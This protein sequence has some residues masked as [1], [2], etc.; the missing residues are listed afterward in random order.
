MADLA[1][2]RGDEVAP[3]EHRDDVDV[4]GIELLIKL[5]DFC[6]NAV[7]C[8][9]D[10]L[11]L[12]PHDD[13]L[14]RRRVLVKAQDSLGLLMRVA[15]FAE[16]ANE[17]R[18]AVSLGHDDIAEIIEGAHEPDAADDQALVAARHP[19]AARIGAV[20]GDRVC[21]V[22]DAY[23]VTQ[24]LSG[25]QIEPEL[26]REASEIIHLCDTRDLPQ[27]RLDDPA[28]I[29]GQV[30]QVLRVRLNRVPVNFQLRRR[31]RV[32]TRRGAWRQ[33]CVPDTLSDPLPF[34]VILGAV[35]KQKIDLG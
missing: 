9:R 28:L 24:E 25:V 23:A 29:F 3:V 18:H 35:A 34:P 22:V 6:V 16:V 15:Q 31:D 21:D 10:V 4:V 17:Y 2:G 1:H 12:Q 27:R 11:V 20:V 33:S 8:V 30:H 26:P 32:E 13:P 7:N 14:D 5:R 19:T